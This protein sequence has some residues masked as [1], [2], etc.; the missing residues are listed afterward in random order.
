MTQLNDPFAVPIQGKLSF[1]PLGIDRDDVELGLPSRGS[2]RLDPKKSLWVVT[3]GRAQALPLPPPFNFAITN[4]DEVRSMASILSVARPGDNVLFLDWD[5]SANS[6]VCEGANKTEAVGEWLAT[7]IRA[8]GIS[9]ATQ[10][11]LVG[12]SWG[13]WVCYFAARSLGRVNSIVALDPAISLEHGCLPPDVAQIDFASVS[14]LSWSIRSSFWGSETRAQTA[15]EAFL[16]NIESPAL[17]V[18]VGNH[19]D[20]HAFF[21]SILAGH[22]TRSKGAVVNYF[23]LK[24]LAGAM[25]TPKTNGSGN[26]DG[27]LDAGYFIDSDALTPLSMKGAD[28]KV[29]TDRY[30]DSASAAKPYSLVID[31]SV[32]NFLTENLP[33]DQ[34]RLSLKTPMDVRIEIR[35]EFA[36]SLIGVTL[37]DSSGTEIPVREVEDDFVP[38]TGA[39]NLDHVAFDATLPKGKSMLELRH[40]RQG[41]MSVGVIYDLVVSPRP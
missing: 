24:R 14:N 41:T 6:W 33:E 12:H 9:P 11:N 34:F 40:L 36:E 10:V 27:S 3:H 22:A 17:D 1:G 23:N 18:D 7:Q 31:R 21:K 16:L 37:R 30:K 5:E 39:P 13:T 26:F 4:S 32:T 15:K 20:A 29:L 28:G 25:A 38:G 2:A 35:G 8:M 19:S